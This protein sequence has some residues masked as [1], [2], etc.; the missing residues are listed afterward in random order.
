MAH[1]SFLSCTSGTIPSATRTSRMS[2]AGQGRAA[3]RVGDVQGHLGARPANIH[4]HICGGDAAWRAFCVCVYVGAWACVPHTHAVRAGVEDRIQPL[5][6]KSAQVQGSLESGEP[7]LGH[8]V[9]TVRTHRLGAAAGPRAARR[10]LGA[11][12]EQLLTLVLEKAFPAELGCA[13]FL[14]P[15]KAKGSQWMAICPPRDGRD[16]C[17]ALGAK[18]GA[19]PSGRSV[20]SGSQGAGTALIWPDSTE[21]IRR[22]LRPMAHAGDSAECSACCPRARGHLPEA[23]AAGWLAWEPGREHAASSR[24]PPPSPTDGTTGEVHR[25][26]PRGP[27][28]PGP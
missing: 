9:R 21:E 3:V 13:R 17:D 20:A 27:R 6:G 24:Q 11:W 1:T 4:Q 12:A 26:P 14:H 5:A 15:R 8:R 23:S 7:G 10:S 25:E 2:G 28:S 18:E 22:R 16:V 19:F